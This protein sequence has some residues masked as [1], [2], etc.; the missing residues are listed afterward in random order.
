MDITTASPVEIDTALA[1]IYQRLYLVQDKI[2]KQDEWIQDMEQGLAKK[3]ENPHLAGRYSAY[4]EERLQRLQDQRDALSSDW[5]AIKAETTPY[6]DEF[7]R[8]GGWSRFFHVTNSNG[9]IHHSMHCSTC[10]PTTRYAWL[11]EMSGQSEEEALQGLGKAGHV[12]CSVCFP[13]APV[14]WYSKRQDPSVCEGSGQYYDSSLPS[15]TGYYSGNWGTCKVCGTRQ[16]VTK[17]LKIRSHK[18]PVGE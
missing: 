13:N 6:D 16:T 11:V 8:R 12:L 2:A 17:G 14:E 9:H 5:F 4:T 18:K 15:R 7:T 10:F 3:A 1:E